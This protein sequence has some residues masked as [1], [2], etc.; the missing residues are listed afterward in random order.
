MH[1]VYDRLGVP[2]LTAPPSPAPGPK[3]PGFDEYMKKTKIW[4]NRLKPEDGDLYKQAMM[5]YENEL[6]YVGPAESVGVDGGLTYM[7]EPLEDHAWS[8]GPAVARQ[9]LI[10][11]KRDL[12]SRQSLKEEYIEVEHVEK[13]NPIVVK[14]KARHGL[15]RGAKV[16]VSGVEGMTEINGKTFTVTKANSQF[17]L[18]LNG[19]SSS[20][21]AYTKGG[22]VNIE[23]KS[24]DLG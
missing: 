23:T 7:K 11:R 12:D 20:W 4:A 1:L 3:D 5:F 15:D 6:G 10:Q 19:D 16:V 17:A 13:A 18:T 2:P 9:S 8:F 24:D 14:L 22:R 21:K